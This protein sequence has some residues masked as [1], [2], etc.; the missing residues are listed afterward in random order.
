MDPGQKYSLRSS[1]RLLGGWDVGPAEYESL[2]FTL[3]LPPLLSI[4]PSPIASALSAQL[5]DFHE[6][7]L[8]GAMTEMTD[9]LYRSTQAQVYIR[10]CDPRG[11]DL[12]SLRDEIDALFTQT[13]GGYPPGSLR[14]LRLDSTA[15]VKVALIGE[16]TDPLI[17]QMILRRKDR[18]K[19]RDQILFITPYYLLSESFP[20]FG[21]QMRSSR[22]NIVVRVGSEAGLQELQSKYPVIREAKMID[23]SRAICF[24]ETVEIA[25]NLVVRLRP[26][27]VAA[28][29]SLPAPEPNVEYVMLP[30]TT[31]TVLRNPRMTFA[32]VFSEQAITELCD[33]DALEGGDFNSLRIHNVFTMS[34]LKDEQTW[35]NL[36]EER[37]KRQSDM[38]TWNRSNIPIRW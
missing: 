35:A 33:A 18:F 2:G 15:T 3:G 8:T 16:F 32:D 17:A 14:S 20:P 13:V 1:P 38:G 19:M 34:L 10:D 11:M 37:R 12:D 4:A 25:A 9:V 36:K 6:D 23:D 22:R 21:S 5:R 31:M 26:Q 30:K 24:V 7:E 29:L 28:I 27:Y